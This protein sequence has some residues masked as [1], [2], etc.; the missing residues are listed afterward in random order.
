[1]DNIDSL[2]ALI[3]AAQEE[4]GYLYTWRTIGIDST[5]TQRLR[6]TGQAR[7]SN[8]PSSHELYNAGLLPARS[9]LL[10]LPS[11]IEE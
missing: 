5:D 6:W 4:D 7:W 9:L 3:A 8:L 2:I 11:I 10:D 1:M